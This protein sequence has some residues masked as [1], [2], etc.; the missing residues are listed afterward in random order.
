MACHD[1]TVSSHGNAITVLWSGHGYNGDSWRFTRVSAFSFVF[2]GFHEL[3]LAFMAMPPRC[4]G[5]FESM[6]A[7]NTS[8]WYNR[9]VVTP[10]WEGNCRNMAHPWAVVAGGDMAVAW[11]PTL[12]QSAG[13]D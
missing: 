13:A 9:P 6:H 12:L 4:R 7:M 11:W 3:S 10:L 1:T 2:T 8:L 5:H